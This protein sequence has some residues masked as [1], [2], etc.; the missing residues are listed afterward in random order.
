M[1]RLTTKRS[2]CEGGR[3]PIQLDSVDAAESKRSPATPALT[4]R[5]VDS[6]PVKGFLRKPSH[7]LIASKSLSFAAQ[8]RN[9]MTIARP[10][11][12]TRAT[13]AGVALRPNVAAVLVRYGFYGVGALFTQGL[14]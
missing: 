11:R 9:A 12:L 13:S 8:R 2:I 3:A 5:A 6:F 7:R 4:K 1:P 10:V 14:G